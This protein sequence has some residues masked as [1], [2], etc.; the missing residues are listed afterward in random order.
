MQHLFANICSNITLNGYCLDFTSC[1]MSVMILPAARW[2]L[3]LRQK[4][5]YGEH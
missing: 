5:L 3:Q 1:L 4:F 2:P